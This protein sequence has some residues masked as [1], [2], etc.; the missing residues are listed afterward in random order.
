[1]SCEALRVNCAGVIP[2]GSLINKNC[3]M[4]VSGVRWIACVMRHSVH[5]QY[6]QGIRC[7][8]FNHLVKSRFLLSFWRPSP[9]C[10]STSSLCVPLKGCFGGVAKDLCQIPDCCYA[11]ISGFSLLAPFLSSVQ[12]SCMDTGRPNKSQDSEQCVQLSRHGRAFNAPSTHGS[13]RVAHRLL[14]FFFSQM[15]CFAR[16]QSIQAAYFVTF[17]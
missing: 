5:R 2:F 17:R 8:N 7:V 12:L 16:V 4:T 1:M 13:P 6:R 10:V 3:E 15:F 11:W 9:K 14:L